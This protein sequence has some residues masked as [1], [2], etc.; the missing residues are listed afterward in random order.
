MNEKPVP[1]RIS[2]NNLIELELNRS[3]GRITLDYVG[4]LSYIICDLISVISLV[5]LV[6]II[7][8]ENKL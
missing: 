8:K 3:E 1:I 2:K 7:V 5:L 4:K 6:F